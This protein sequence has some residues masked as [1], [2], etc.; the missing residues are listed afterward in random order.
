MNEPTRSRN[1]GASATSRLPRVAWHRHAMSIALA[2]SP[3][4][5]VAGAQ[6]PAACADIA[7]VAPARDKAPAQ[8]VSPAGQAVYAEPGNPHEDLGAGGVCV[9]LFGAADRTLVRRHDRCPRA[10]RVRCDSPG[11]LRPRRRREVVARRRSSCSPGR[12]QRAREPAP[13][14]RAPA[15]QERPA[16]E[17]RH[18]R[19][20]PGAAPATPRPRR[21]RPGGPQRDDRGG[22]DHAAPATLA[23]IDSVD[24]GNLAWM[25]T[26]VRQRGW[27]G[28]DLVGMD[29][30][31]AAF[32]LVQHAGHGF[33]KEMLPLV[34]R[35]IGAA[36]WPARTS[37][38]SPIA[39]SSATT[40]RSAT[41]PRPSPSH[42]G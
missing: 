13:P 37:P 28:R 6:R 31:E 7:Y 17:P 23:R 35:R 2:L 26:L 40:G 39:C 1:S 20:R 11:R 41:A 9:A 24:A 27:P 30:T 38:C 34:E 5:A 14:A 21:R 15:R 3:P 8:S 22:S 16:R 19:H 4:L 12:R 42:S 32:L 18:P 29:G 10:F 33:Q 36:T 25:R